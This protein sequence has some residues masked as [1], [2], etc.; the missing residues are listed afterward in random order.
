[1]EV[2]AD[3]SPPGGSEKEAV[4]EGATTS[5]PDVEMEDLS[6]LLSWVEPGDTDTA[7]GKAGAGM[8][9]GVP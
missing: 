1:L 3:S 4:V 2:E 6:Q 7:G 8:T 9:V 5:L